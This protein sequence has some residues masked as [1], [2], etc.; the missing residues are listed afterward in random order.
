MYVAS[1]GMMLGCKG[2]HT[3]GLHKAYTQGLHT[4]LTRKAYTQ[5]LHAR[6]TK[7]LT[8][9]VKYTTSPTFVLLAN[10]T[11]S[12]AAVKIW[13]WGARS[14]DPEIYAHCNIQLMIC[15]SV[16]ENSAG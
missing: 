4:R 2:F 7:Y 12:M 5:G 10:V 13:M 3:Q 1:H 8:C 9:E 11:L 16:S 14:R 15:T 6:L